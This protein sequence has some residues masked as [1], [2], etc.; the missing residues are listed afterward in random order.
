M[1]SNLLDDDLSVLYRIL[2][3]ASVGQ[4]I[5]V[6]VGAPKRLTGKGRD[7]CDLARRDE[8]GPL[9]ISSTANFNSLGKREEFRIIKR[10][11]NSH[12]CGSAAQWCRSNVQ[13]D[14]SLPLL[15]PWGSLIT[16]AADRLALTSDCCNH[17]PNTSTI[18]LILYN[19]FYPH[20]HLFFFL[21]STLQHVVA[22]T[23]ESGAQ[24]VAG[25]DI[26]QG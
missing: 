19:L 21:Y 3:A 12:V 13:S 5:N 14:Y 7:Y 20:V 24:S 25:I 26:E 1:P 11:L 9:R 16:P 10:G 4:A 8:Y 17:P 18:R 2:E 6:C 23:W 22:R 15:T